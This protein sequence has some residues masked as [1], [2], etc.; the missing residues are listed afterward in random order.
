MRLNKKSV[1]IHSLPV[2]LSLALALPFTVERATK[3][4]AEYDNEPTSDGRMSLHTLR[5]IVASSLTVKENLR[6]SE[7]AK[8]QALSNASYKCNPPFQPYG[9]QRGC[10]KLVVYFELYKFLNKKL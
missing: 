10:A 6:D 9:F 2:P 5:V 8:N 7:T 4:H 1:E 3:I